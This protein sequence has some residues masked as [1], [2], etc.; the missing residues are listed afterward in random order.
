MKLIS[1][2]T[3]VEEIKA[4]WHKSGVFPYHGWKLD[5][6][7]IVA[8]AELLGP[9]ASIAELVTILEPLC[10]LFTKCDECQQPSRELVEFVENGGYE[11]TP[12]RICRRCIAK[13]LAM[14][15]GGR[16]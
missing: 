12:E 16:P 14:L 1:P 4:R 9:S 3:E 13:A 10:V 15:E 2:E 8:A 5:H 6:P 11:N 7:E